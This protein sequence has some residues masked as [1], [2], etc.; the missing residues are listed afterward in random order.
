MRNF[1]SRRFAKYLN[2]IFICNDMH[3]IQTVI[4]S[5]YR[6]VLDVFALIFGLSSTLDSRVGDDFGEDLKGFIGVVGSNSNKIFFLNF[7]AHCFASSMDIQSPC[8]LVTD[9]LR[10]ASSRFAKADRLFYLLHCLIA[11]VCVER[12]LLSAAMRVNFMSS[13]QLSPSDDPRP[14]ASEVRAQLQRLIAHPLFAHSKRYPVLLAYTVEQTLLGQADALKER[15]IGVVAFERASDYDVS[16]DPVVRMTAAEV[17]KRLCQYY[18]DAD[19]AG[20]LV[21]ELPVGSYVPLF[22]VPAPAL[23]HENDFSAREHKQEIRGTFRTV[24][25]RRFGVYIALFVA[26][27]L[28][29]ALGRLHLPQPPSNFAR[30]WSPLTGSSSRIT[31]C[32]GEPGQN[33]DHKRLETSATPLEGSLDVSDVTTLARSLVPIVGRHDGFRVLGASETRFAQLREGP[34]V[35][36]GAFD[37]AWTMRISQELPF[38]FIYEDG[39]RKIVDRR[40]SSRRFWTLDW[41]VP[42]QKLARDYAIVAR[43]HDTLTGQPVVI[44]AGILGEGTEA[45]SEAVSNPE[46]LDAILRQAPKNWDHANLEAVIETQVIEGHAAAPRVVAVETW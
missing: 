18:Y 9:N 33:A 24:G 41:Q 39:L 6:S 10:P 40:S 3:G 16:I 21:I 14:S 36:I 29:V 23:S 15:S 46:S 8:R 34:V 13:M 28:G 17:R 5:C 7:V 26:V 31:Y 38:S 2:K 12:A 37:N 44:L 1:L 19:H 11:I 22:H 25:V 32:L 30:F 42:E 4:F 45:A 43:I 35:L 27:L 20:E